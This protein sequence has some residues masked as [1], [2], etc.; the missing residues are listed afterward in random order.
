MSEHGACFLTIGI[1]LSFPL[2]DRSVHVLTELL[3]TVPCSV[4]GETTY[5]QTTAYHLKR[6][7]PAQLKMPRVAI[8]LNSFVVFLGDFS[9]VRLLCSRGE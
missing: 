3:R 6:L 4:Q 1:M 8:I 7:K 2:N 9:L 5:S